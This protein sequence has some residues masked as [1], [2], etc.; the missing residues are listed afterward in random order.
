MKPLKIE[1]WDPKDLIPYEH[2][3]KKHPDEQIAKIAES[4]QKFGWDQPIVVDKHGVIIKGHGRR[5]AALKL[6]LA[7]V[8]VLI[9]ADLTPDQVKAA[10]LADNRA[11]LSDID[12]NMLRIEMAEI[13]GIDELLGG[14]FDDKELDFL[15]ADLG[16]MNSG[17]FVTDMDLVVSEQKADLDGRIAEATQKRVP[18]AKA[19]GVKDVPATASLALAAFMVRIEAETGLKGGDALAKWAEKEIA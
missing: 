2:N 8:P 15:T 18:V 1:L 9:R 11:A 7:K 14:I 13:T 5:L 4:T 19:M 6:G 10:R 3:S 12:A 17:A 16:E